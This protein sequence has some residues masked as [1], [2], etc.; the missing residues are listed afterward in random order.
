MSSSGH[1]DCRRWPASAAV[2]RRLVRLKPLPRTSTARLWP[3]LC[4]TYAAERRQEP[5]R[6]RQVQDSSTQD[7]GI[8]PGN[9]GN[10]IV[11]ENDRRSAQRH[12]MVW[13]WSK[14]RKPAIAVAGPKRIRNEEWIGIPRLDP[15]SYHGVKFCRLPIWMQGDFRLW[16]RHRLHT[17]VQH[18]ATTQKPNVGNPGSRNL[19][20]HAVDW[21]NKIIGRAS[22]RVKM[23]TSLGLAW[24]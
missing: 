1:C 11:L 2:P 19:S 5:V 13:S 23:P 4:R 6:Y 8:E 20:F 21:E 22:L 14:L 17:N 16:R 24:L 3:G 9:D 10:R 18:R 12:W 7:L 15:H